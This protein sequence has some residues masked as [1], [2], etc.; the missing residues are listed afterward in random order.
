MLDF[1]GILYYTLF[2]FWM[3][4]SFSISVMLAFHSVLLASIFLL[5]LVHNLVLFDCFLFPTST[6][7]LLPSQLLD[8]P[9]FLWTWHLE[10]AD[11]VLEEHQT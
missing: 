2:T 10:N 8:H 6:D 7:S 9:R 4:F 5:K 1:M 11:A 3:F